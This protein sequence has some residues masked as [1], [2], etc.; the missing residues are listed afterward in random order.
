MTHVMTNA[1]KSISMPTFNFLKE[2][3]VPQKALEMDIVAIIIHQNVLQS[4]P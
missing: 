1:F 2:V 3:I 4:N